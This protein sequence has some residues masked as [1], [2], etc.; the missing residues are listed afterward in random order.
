M[1]SINDYLNLA[2]LIHPEQPTLHKN[3][4]CIEASRGE[5]LKAQQ[6]LQ[7]ALHLNPRD[8]VNHRNF[9][10]VYP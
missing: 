9:A 5:Y 10:K 2:L 7:H 1:L 3:M 4:G 8:V 6:H